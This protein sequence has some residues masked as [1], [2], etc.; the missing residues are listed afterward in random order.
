MSYPHDRDQLAAD[1]APLRPVLDALERGTKRSALR[2]FVGV[3]ERGHTLVEVFPTAS[4]AVA[5]WQERRM[6]WSDTPTFART[7]VADEGGFSPRC[8]CAQTR[9]V[10]WSDL[11]E[12]ADSDRKRAVLRGQ[13]LAETPAFQGIAQFALQQANAM[14][15]PK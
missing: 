5:V 6:D 11:L 10:P 4:G 12:A 3:C 9:T 2:S 14:L 13:L 15:K 8:R 1:Y 7:L